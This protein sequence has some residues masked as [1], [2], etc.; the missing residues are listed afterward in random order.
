MVTC[1][2]ISFFFFFNECPGAVVIKQF[3]RFFVNS[4]VMCIGQ[5][6]ASTSLV[7]R[8]YPGHLKPGRREFDYH[9]LPGNGTLTPMNKVMGS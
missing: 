4:D 2:E 3:E 6:K 9:R 1:I 5:M 8:S 7:P